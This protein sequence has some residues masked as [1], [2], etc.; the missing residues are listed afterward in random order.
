[1]VWNAVSHPMGDGSRETFTRGVFGG[2]GLDNVRMVGIDH[3]ATQT[4]A[5]TW[6][7]TLDLEV[8]G[9]GLH[10]SFDVAGE[11]GRR[12][13][14]EIRAGRC[15]GSSFTFDHRPGLDDCWTTEADGSRLLNV[16]TATLGHICPCTRPAYP[17][18]SVRVKETPVAALFTPP[19]AAQQ[20]RIAAARRQS[21]Q[22]MARLNLDRLA[23]VH[24]RGAAEV[25]D[26]A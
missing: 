11:E 10:Y 22:T 17:Q 8:D 3:D 12:V 26:C 21:E 19:T 1:M 14:E 9:R 13:A 4:L 24:P 6:D 15:R 23:R 18:T 5:A 7:G 20:Q 25:R 2:S 16:H